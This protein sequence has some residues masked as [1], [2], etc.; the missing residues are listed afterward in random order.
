MIC[1]IQLKACSNLQ[2]EDDLFTVGVVA[3]AS[4]RVEGW[5]CT[6]AME[7]SVLVGPGCA[8]WLGLAAAAAN[9]GA[10]GCSLVAVM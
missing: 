3:V 4:S 5:P 9:K 10:E 2:A 6:M 8:D 7:V 1:Q